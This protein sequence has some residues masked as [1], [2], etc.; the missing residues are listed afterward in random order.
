MRV[1]I[2]AKGLMLADENS[3]SLVV[4]CGEIPTKSLLNE[5]YVALGT[6]F[7]VSVFVTM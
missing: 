4:L 2:L 5:V 3:V 7:N 1:G 6:Q